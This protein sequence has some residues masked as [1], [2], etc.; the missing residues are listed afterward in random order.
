MDT[1]K[2]YL[3]DRLVLLLLSINAF[4]ALI[5]SVLILLRLDTSRSDGYFV[6][7]R[8]NLGLNAYQLGGYASLLAFIAFAI[9]VLVFH[10]VI[11]HRV[12]PQRRDVAVV[13]LGFG[14][15]L[16]ALTLIVSNAL[17]VL[18]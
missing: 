3:H 10:T 14:T 12:F 16:L 15:L 6:Q 8:E 4:I 7:Y 5:T 13:V 18:R 1:S 11:S 9:F 17:L 2:K